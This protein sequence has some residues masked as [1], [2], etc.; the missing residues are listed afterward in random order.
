[1]ATLAPSR[2]SE[3]AAALPI[4]SLP[5]VTIA[6]LPASPK[7]ITPPMLGDPRRFPA[8]VSDRRS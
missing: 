3:V 8:R 1:M 4:P 7:S 5:P 6:T 2:A